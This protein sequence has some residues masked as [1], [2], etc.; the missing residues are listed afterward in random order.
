MVTGKVCRWKYL[1]PVTISPQ[2]AEDKEV[3]SSD[4]GS[5]STWPLLF[6]SSSQRGKNFE[7]S[8]VSIQEQI[9]RGPCQIPADKA[10]MVPAAG[11]H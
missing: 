1:L 6:F 5:A 7:T 8:Q 9:R 11:L 2:R 3:V 4:L 10:E